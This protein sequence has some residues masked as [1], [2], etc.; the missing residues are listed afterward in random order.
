MARMAC[1]DVPALPLQL[2]IRHHPD[3]SDRPVAVLEKD[4]LHGEILWVNER[5]R[6]SGVLSGMSYATGLAL[7][8]DLRGAEIASHETAAE[9]E[10]SAE[11]LRSFTPNIEPSDKHR[12]VFW[13]DAS[14]LQPLFESLLS[15][16]EQVQTGLRTIG[17]RS[18]IAVGFTRFGTYALARTSQRGESSRVPSGVSVLQDP[19]SEQR[20]ARQVAL[21]RLYIDPQLRDV[22]DKLG[23]HTVG[24]FV[25]LPSAGIR[26]RF[27]ADAQKFH[28]LA[29]GDLALPLQPLPIVESLTRHLDLDPPETDRRRL[30]CFVK[31]ALDPL[32]ATLA[33][34]QQALTVLELWLR[35]ETGLNEPRAEQR[36]IVRTAAPTLDRRQVLNLVRLRVEGRALVAP[37]TE[38]DL[39]VTAVPATREQLQLF[40]QESRRDLRAAERAV[41]RVRAEFGEGVVLRARLAEGHLPEAMFAWEPLKHV[42]R[43]TPR[44]VGNRPMV[45]R[46]LTRPRRLPSRLRHEPDGWMLRGAQHGHVVQCHGPYVVSGGW[47][48]ALVHREYYFARTR[49]DAWSW[50]YYDRRRR[51]W[52]LHG[53]VE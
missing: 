18:R 12:G 45:R 52:F 11:H 51:M 14:G 2:L 10:A 38:I 25:D 1:V 42:V 41:A 47:W 22:L 13:L 49:D 36:E 29:S 53:E 6:R 40:E 26:K 43:P 50:I 8:S 30:L 5:A 21:S 23:V 16:G 27:G 17:F 9:V 39:C 19:V 28:R 44:Q 4:T 15:W 46:F 32:F 34:R 31:H 33:A 24:A 7:A 20:A 48:R 3:W 37:V 35:L